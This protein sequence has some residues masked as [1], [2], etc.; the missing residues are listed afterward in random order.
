M[1]VGRDGRI[2]TQYGRDASTLRF[3]SEDP[4]LQNLPRP[5]PSDP[6]DPA[7][8][9]RNL[10]VA[11]EGSVLYARDY[12]GIEA[13]LTG[14][15]ALDPRYIRLAKRDVHTYYTVYALYELEGGKRIQAVD[16]PDLSWPDERLFPYLDVL[17]SQFKKE[18]NSLYKHLVHAANFMQGAKGAQAKIFSE[19]GIEYPVA[20]VQKVM[21]VYY[22]LFPKIK[23]W[24]R[25]VLDEAEKDGYIRN[26]FDYVHRFSRVYDYTKER[27][28]WVRKPGTDANRVIAF[29]PQS[30]A[31]AIITEAL[32][33]LYYERF[34]EAGQFLRL[35]VHDELMFEFP[36]EVWERGNLIVKEEMERAVPQLRMPASW[37]MGETLGILTEAKVDL[38][39]PSRWGT[40]KGIKDS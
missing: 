17:K 27:G 19:T 22:A 16:L 32:L 29:K 7:N 12:S 21:D 39:A 20:T 1:P 11:G 5:N 30:T 26:P 18:R 31:V 2:H 4:N 14:Y 23:Q 37:G 36:R 13:V 10:V 9:V 8:I 35:Q 33:R 28:E 25:N 3:T 38:G 34:E 6:H 15:F 24:H 40:M